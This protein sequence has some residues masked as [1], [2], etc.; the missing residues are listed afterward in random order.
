MESGV[1]LQTLHRWK[2]QALVDAGVRT[3]FTSRE[4]SDVREARERIKELE[5]ELHLVKDASEIFDALTVA[6]PKEVKPSR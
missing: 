5:D 1:P 2:S 6:E 3:G 4:L